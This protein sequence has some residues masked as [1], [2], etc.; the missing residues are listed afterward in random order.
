[1]TTVQRWT[2]RETRALRHAL[3]MSV[4][5]FAGYLGV[6]VR[7]VAAWDAQGVQVVPRPEI[8]AALDT[9][10]ERGGD[11]VR[12]RFAS[13]LA[14]HGGRPGHSDD[15]DGMFTLSWEPDLVRLRRAAGQL[16]AAD[17]DLSRAPKPDA[18][19]PHVLALRW[20]VAGPE[21]STARSG[22]GR[23]IGLA[24]IGRLSSMRRLLKAI[25]NAHGGGAAF[26]M[27]VT[28]LRREVSPLL[29][30]R[31]T[32]AIGRQLCGTA[33]GLAL[34]VGWMAY[35]AGDHLLAR[36]YLGQALRLAH[37]AGDRLFG[38][39]VLAALSHQALHIGQVTL[40]I[41][42]ARAARTGT[43]QVAPPRAVAMLAAME[44][45]ALA[46]SRDA[47]ACRAALHDSEKAL[48]HTRPGDGPQWL[49]FDTGGM[50]GHAARAYRYLRRGADCARFA[51]QAVA[52]CQPGHS[53]TRAQRY[54][55]LAAAHL[56][57]GE[58][59]HAAATGSQVVRQAWNL[60]SRHVDEEIITLAKAIKRRNT[61][62]G[63]EFLGQAREYLT[64]R[65]PGASLNG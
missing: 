13:L 11:E 21:P 35:D 42:F 6:G 31:Y 4:R 1:M 14:E 19:A 49:D 32:D 8:Q 12:Q 45:M 51:E 2:G 58:L 26:P 56:Q 61:G 48:E 43:T 40:A 64:T 34:D 62:S 41:D 16:W 29:G 38:G 46:A 33:A 52:A 57:T 22:P 20:L 30:G 9:A 55:I 7:T 54:A 24:D 17:L 47:A 63:R 25:D 65:T 3:R 28:Y 60:H 23:R 5:A 15:D 36:A 50:Y 18:A 59:E 37:A 53:R 10:L 44:A 39:R 27:A